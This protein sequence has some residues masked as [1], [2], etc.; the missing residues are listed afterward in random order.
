MAVLRARLFDIKRREE[1][2]KIS[3]MRRSQVSTGDRSARI[4]T[5]NFPQG[6][7]T[8]HRVGLTLYRLPEVLEGDL[9]E[10]IAALGAAHQEGRLADGGRDDED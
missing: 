6:R 10:L 8:D 5:Y 4:R 7:I 1:D 9:D 3:Q 2:A